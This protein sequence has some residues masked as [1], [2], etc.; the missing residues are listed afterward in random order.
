[1]PLNPLLKD[2]PHLRES[3][4]ANFEG[5][6]RKALIV[7]YVKHIETLGYKAVKVFGNDMFDIGVSF[8]ALFEFKRPIVTKELRKHTTFFEARD[9][10]DFSLRKFKEEVLDTTEMATLQSFDKMLKIR[11]WNTGFTDEEILSAILPH[12]RSLKIDDVYYDGKVHIPN[13]MY[14]FLFTEM[15]FRGGGGT[16]SRVVQRAKG[17]GTHAV[18]QLSNLPD[19]IKE[20]MQRRGVQQYG[21]IP[22]NSKQEQARNIQQGNP[23][24][25]RLMRR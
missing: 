1:M 22:S 15:N 13:N 10:S 19:H 24:G 20:E 3:D 25:S 8:R 12:D 4:Y 17:S 21:Q 18:H 6:E 14:N 5:D 11:L 9:F 23:Y 16:N 2:N 7:E